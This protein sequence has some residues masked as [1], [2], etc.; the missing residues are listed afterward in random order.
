[1]PVRNGASTLRR[2]LSAI[3][4]GDVSARVVVI[5]DH[6]SDASARIA[7]DCGADVVTAPG[8]GGLGAA[9]NLALD[10]CRTRY[11][12]FVNCDCYPRPDW[13][14]LLRDAL[15]ES[16]AAVAGGYQ[17][18]LRHARLAERWKAVHLRQD[19]GDDDIDDPDYLSG[20]N[21]VMDLDRVG[22]MRFDPRYTMA[23]EDVD[24]C[25]RLRASGQL[26]VYRAAPTVDH[27]HAETLRS[28][29][30]KVWSY[31]IFSRSVGGF[32]G[33]SGALRACARMHRRPNDQVRNAL[34]T[35]LRALRVEFLIVD[36]FLLATSLRF[37]LIGGRQPSRISAL[38]NPV[39][40]ERNGE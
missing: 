28:L 35:D 36:L 39:V 1:M 37:F 38:L 30:L 25:R 19:L 33:I 24:F 16:G 10:T 31:G 4:S 22:A 29:P 11:L 8:S 3:R 27:D 23:Y 12:A 34:I 6:S 40:Q 5:D 2:C 9:R 20:G 21:L 26:L 14:R 7:A 32:T 17:H 13:L 18:E 15:S